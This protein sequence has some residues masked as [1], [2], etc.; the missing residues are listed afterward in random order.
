MQEIVTN[1]ILGVVQG[2][3]EWL[4]ISSSGH[5]VLFEHL[6]QVRQDLSYD[7]FLHIAS[8]GVMLVYFRA[9]IMRLVRASV[10]KGS[11]DDRVLIVHIAIATLATV[12]VALLVRPFESTLRGL[13]WVGLS[14]IVNAV[15]LYFTK[16]S[17]GNRTLHWQMAAVI[18]LAQGLAAV[19]A[20]SRSGLTIAVALLFGLPREL[21]FRFSFLIAIPAIAGA[22][23]LTIGD[24]VWQP[25]YL[26]GFTVTAVV[27][28]LSLI[29]LKR[30]VIR[31][32]LYL[33]WIYNAVLAVIVLAAWKF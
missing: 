26:V 3:T 4:P 11:S 15:F 14:L 21:A 5:L 33:F 7:L 24:L 18:G 16:K 20:I 25:A 13:F 23:I 1:I 29:W 31:D 8:L 32:S 9:D 2:F 22:V 17:R 19:P 27:G 28:Y 12:M 10:G 30:L 6:L